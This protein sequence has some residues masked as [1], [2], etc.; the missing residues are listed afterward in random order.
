MKEMRKK[1]IKEL[2]DIIKKKQVRTLFQP[3]V[4]L[5][6]QKLL[7]YEALSRGPV[8]MPLEKPDVLFDL[9]QA[10]GKIL[11]LEDLCHQK[12]FENAQEL[13]PGLKL[14]I[15]VE[16]PLLNKSL[17]KKRIKLLSKLAFKAEDVVFEITERSAIQNIKKFRE[18][19][20]LF[21]KANFCFA[22]DDT[23]TGYNSIKVFWELR[24]AY[25]KL[26]SFLIR[27]IHRDPLK[28][29]FTKVLVNC[30]RQI[31]AKVVAEAVENRAELKILL[32]LGVDYAQGYLFARPGKPF[33]APK[34][35]KL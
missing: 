35:I 1:R 22:L 8:G 5:K 3:I 24:P 28:E 6:D 7:G 29:D 17:Y 30:A 19:M 27:N 33:P 15:N 25:L 13:P 12:A 10:N 32:K 31:K 18:S 23:G 14:F 21:H 4:S 20:S 26:S 16:V 11:E 34:K 2:R 9:A